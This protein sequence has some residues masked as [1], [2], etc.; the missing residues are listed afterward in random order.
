M[1]KTPHGYKVECRL[2][3]GPVTRLLLRGQNEVDH[4]ENKSW[5]DYKYAF[6][7]IILKFHLL[8]DEMFLT[9]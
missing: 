4:F 9:S 6:N 1:M 3:E 2:Q 8:A 7:I 5:R